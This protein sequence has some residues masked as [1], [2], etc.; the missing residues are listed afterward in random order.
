M[1]IFRVALISF[2]LFLFASASHALQGYRGDIITAGSAMNSMS[3]EVM[4]T[5]NKLRAANEALLSMRVPQH[6]FGDRIVDQQ[7]IE[8]NFI[9]HVEI[10]PCNWTFTDCDKWTWRRYRFTE[11]AKLMLDPGHAGDIYKWIVD[12]QWRYKIPLEKLFETYKLY[13]AGDVQ[14]GK[15]PLMMI[16]TEYGQTVED[17]TN[18]ADF[19]GAFMNKHHFCVSASMWAV[20]KA[21]YDKCPHMRPVYDN[22]FSDPQCVQVF[23]SL[24]G[25]RLI[26]WLEEI[27]VIEEY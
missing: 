13:A 21:I 22:A 25:G 18:F 5:Q 14:F 15:I 16:G 6:A 26:W 23:D 19:Y 12:Q 11:H 9:F 3:M 17:Y 27:G 8:E 24:T 10:L 20:F 2:C 7:L 4:W 1:K